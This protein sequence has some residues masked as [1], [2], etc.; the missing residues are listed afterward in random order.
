[1]MVLQLPLFDDPS[2]SIFP[3]LNPF[4]RA[5]PPLGSFPLPRQPFF[6]PVEKVRVILALFSF[7]RKIFFSMLFSLFSM[8]TLPDQEDPRP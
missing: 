2:A 4:S 6:F 8:D 3:V 1:M 7:Q 5:L